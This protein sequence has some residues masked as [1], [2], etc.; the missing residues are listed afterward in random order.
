MVDFTS[1]LYLG[2]RHPSDSVGS[3]EALTLGQPSALHE[4][5]GAESV[6]AD[7]A[8]LQGCEAGALL[9][10]TLH[11]FWDLFAML[12]RGNTVILRDAG[13]YP[14]GRW[15]IERAKALGAGVRS[16]PHHDATVL[17][18]LV[19]EATRQRLQ[20]IVVSDG[21]CPRCGEVAP[22]GIYS[23]LARRS[24]GYL[25]IDDT[26]GLGILGDNPDAVSPYGS[27]GGGSLRWHRTFGP[28]I[29]TCSSLAK[30][31]GVPVAVLAGDGAL[32][33]RFRRE[34]ETRVHC[35][36]PSVAV[37][38]AARSALTANRSSGDALRRCL[39]HL[40]A[41][42]RTYLIAAGLRPSGQLPFPVQTVV[43]ARGRTTLLHEQLLG[44]GI[45]GLLT[46]TCK[47]LTTSLTLVVT[48][49]H[50][51]AEIEHAGRAIARAARATGASLNPQMTTHG[52]VRHG[53]V[54]NTHS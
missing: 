43:S 11:L 53:E 16:F 48:T 51:L 17:E 25:V 22:I 8:R 12:A 19:G 33:D 34:S 38:R 4:P 44:A 28:H 6:A 30:G 5:P 21:Y 37:V 14:V 45:V 41:R 49:R 26:Q 42:L 35:S 40:V 3:W 31:F 32:I 36:P 54:S 7:L 46:R 18:R 13:A 24:G 39:V 29:I 27:G 9:P 50:R 47:A 10:S 1:A 20:P 2:W 15:G 52:R 23:E